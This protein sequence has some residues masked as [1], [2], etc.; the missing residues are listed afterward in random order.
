[1]RPYGPVYPACQNRNT[2]SICQEM[3][4]SSVRTDEPSNEADT[5]PPEDVRV[6]AREHL[7]LR[8]PARRHSTS[9]SLA[10]GRTSKDKRTDNGCTGSFV[11]TSV[12]QNSFADPTAK[13]RHAATVIPASEAGFCRCGVGEARR[14]RH[15]RRT[16]GG[17][18]KRGKQRGYLRMLTPQ[19]QGRRRQRPVRPQHRHH[20]RRGGDR[21]QHVGRDREGVR[22][23]AI[24]PPDR[25]SDPRLQ[26][27]H[28]VQ[29]ALAPRRRGGLRWTSLRSTPTLSGARLG[30]PVAGVSAYLPDK[31]WFGRAQPG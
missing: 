3:A 9:P 6:Q 31:C 20:P 17:R 29:P 2:L 4:D 14:G 15:W 28:G 21:G 8:V 10:G 13:R 7:G 23:A 26:R 30:I 5:H 27:R 16:Q 18:C 11:P 1:M 22:G 19:R 24:E 25:I 12:P